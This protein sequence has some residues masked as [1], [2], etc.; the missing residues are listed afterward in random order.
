MSPIIRN[1]T[2]LN[3]ALN[4]SARGEQVNRRTDSRKFAAVPLA[5]N[6]LGNFV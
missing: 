5:K 2:G 1:R 6:L 4:F 3:P